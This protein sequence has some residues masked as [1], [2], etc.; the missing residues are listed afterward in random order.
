MTRFLTTI[1]LNDKA[2]KLG[3]LWLKSVDPLALPCPIC[4]HISPQNEK[5]L[6]F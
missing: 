6:F 5:L 4:L 2:M 1:L 3:L